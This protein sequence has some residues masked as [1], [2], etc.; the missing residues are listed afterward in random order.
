MTS[1]DLPLVS[2]W[3]NAPEVQQWYGKGNASKEQVEA[4]YQEELDE[5]PRRT[6]HYII[7]IDGMDAGLIQTY[8]LSSYPDVDEYVQEGDGTAM[9]DIFLTPEFMHKGHGSHIM[10][11]FLWDYVFSGKLFFANKCTIGP[12]PKNLSAIRMYEKAGFRWVKT[13]WLPFENEPEYIMVMNK[14]DLKIT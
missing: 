9:V 5:V 8:L 13:I 11:K 3:Q 2:D 7:Q 4:H 1:N 6:W 12:E 14:N 10:R